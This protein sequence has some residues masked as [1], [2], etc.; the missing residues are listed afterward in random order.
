MH[1]AAGCS[2]EAGESDYGSQQNAWTPVK[3]ALLASLASGVL[4]EVRASVERAIERAEKLIDDWND[5]TPMAARMLAEVRKHAVTGR[6]GIS[7]VLPNNKYVLLAHRFLHRK[8]GDDW[9]SVEARL[10]WHTLSA[11]AKTLTGDRRGK[12]FA[13]PIQCWRPSSI[14]S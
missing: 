6:Q 7:L 4:N 12:H 14:T 10:E 8:L 2:A 11:V 1:P 3:L 13:P 9:A 5:A